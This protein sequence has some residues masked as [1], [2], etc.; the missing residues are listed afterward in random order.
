[1]RPAMIASPMRF[2]PG[3]GMRWVMMNG[4]GGGIEGEDLVL[5]DF[6]EWAVVHGDGIVRKYFE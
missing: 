3:V 6:C 2:M 1:M 4:G 5:G